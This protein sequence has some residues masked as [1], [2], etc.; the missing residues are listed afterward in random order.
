MQYMTMSLRKAIMK[1]SE[2]ESTKNLKNTKNRT[3]ENNTKY[4]KQN[5]HC[6]GFYKKYQKNFK[7]KS[8]NWK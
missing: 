8:D 3:I 7:T 6:K 1:R 2:R 5:N 4:K